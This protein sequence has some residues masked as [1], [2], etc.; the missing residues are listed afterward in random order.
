MTGRPNARLIV[1]GYP[2]LFET[3]SCGLL[4]MST[5]KRALLNEAADTLASVTSG[6]A[7]AA[8]ATF[9]DTRSFFAGHGVCGATR[10]SSTSPASSRRTTRTP[11]ATGTASCPH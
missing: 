11:T 5:T 10:G 2:R 7:A 1:L 6:R 3:G 8:G 9:V 4:A